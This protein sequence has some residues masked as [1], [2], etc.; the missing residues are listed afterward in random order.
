MN[1]D[2]QLHTLAL[3][4][5]DHAK[6]EWGLGTF[7]IYCCFVL[8]AAGLISV[9]RERHAEF[10]FVAFQRRQDRFP[11]VP[12]LNDVGIYPSSWVKGK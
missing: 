11:K 8:I 7:Y 6:E 5:G 12:I 10:F 1:L 3:S 9:D 2:E 4:A